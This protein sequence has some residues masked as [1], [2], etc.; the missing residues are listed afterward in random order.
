MTG[1]PFE[2]TEEQQALRVSTRRLLDKTSNLERVREIMEGADPDPMVWRTL[3]EQM[4]LTAV[5]IPEEWGGAGSGWL[6]QIVIFEEMGRSLFTGPYF[7]TVALATPA[8]LLAD[9]AEAH[10]RFLP[11]IAAG[12]L[13]ATLAFVEDDGD[14]ALKECQ[15]RAELIDGVWRVHGTK[16]FVRDGATA[17]LLLVVAR[18]DDG[19]SL[20]AVDGDRRAVHANPS[21][22]DGSDGTARLD[23]L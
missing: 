19:L 7:S 6:E 23:R 5:I 3:T 14:W 22:V 12:D 21:R 1:K 18:T 4:G 17:D 9:D 11:R 20:F 16:S 10:E 15:A 2:T 13:T 8:L